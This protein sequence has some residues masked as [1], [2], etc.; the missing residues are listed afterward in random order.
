MFSNDIYADVA[1]ADLE[2]KRMARERY[3]LLRDDFSPRRPNL[4]RRGLQALTARLADRPQTETLV[5]NR[6]LAK[7]NRA[8][9]AR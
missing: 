8:P 4:F 1:K 6:D 3:V 9:L 5:P 2:R 7:L